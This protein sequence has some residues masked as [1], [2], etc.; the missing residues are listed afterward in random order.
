MKIVILDSSPVDVGGLS[1]EKIESLGEVK[2]YQNTPYKEPNLVPERIGDAD[3]AISNKTPISAKTMDLCPNLKLI[4]MLSTGYNIVDYEYAATKNIKV[5]NVPN[6]GSNAVAQ[7]AVGMLLEICSHFSHHDKT[8]KEGRWESG[9]KWCYWDYPMIELYQ[10]TAGIIGLGSIGRTTAKI[11]GAL[12]MKVLAHSRSRN[13]EGEKLA[14]YVDLD[15]LLANSDVIFLH[16]PLLKETEGIINKESI[17]K[18]KD[19]VILINNS[20]GQLIVEEDLAQ[21][22]NCGKIYAAGLDVVSKEPIRKDN[23]LLGAKNCMITPHISW[24]ATETRQRIMDMTYDNLK[25]FIE[26]NPINIVNMK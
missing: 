4:A 22:L 19:G 3:I 25:A 14:E 11:L 15:T 6:Y 16:C 12:G 1:W 24:V 9:G 23:P 20:R 2:I 7:Y 10:K 18:M 13:P 8:V 21:A 26:G 5:A 17:A